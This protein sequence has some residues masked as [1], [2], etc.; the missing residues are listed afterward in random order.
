VEHED[1]SYCAYW[2]IKFAPD[3]SGA[4]DTPK[5]NLNLSGTPLSTVTPVS[6]DCSVVLAVALSVLAKKRYDACSRIGAGTN[7]TN[8][9]VFTAAV[10]VITLV[11]LDVADA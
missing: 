6:V 4:D 2:S 3:E 11:P 8:A 10:P 7:A 1:P 9:P 5:F